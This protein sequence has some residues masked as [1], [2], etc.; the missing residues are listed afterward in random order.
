MESLQ[1]ACVNIFSHFSDCPV[2]FIE[3]L[4][5]TR[6]DLKERKEKKREWMGACQDSFNAVRAKMAAS[7]AEQ[8]SNFFSSLYETTTAAS[9]KKQKGSKAAKKAPPV[10]SPTQGS[11]KLKPKPDM[12]AVANA[13]ID[14]IPFVKQISIDDL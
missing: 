12:A 4:L 10:T 6:A 14:K 13:A 9:G 11:P 2:A 1:L 5:E 7:K 8:R 3:R